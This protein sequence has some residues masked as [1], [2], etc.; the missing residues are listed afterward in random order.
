MFLRPLR[1]ESAVYVFFCCCPCTYLLNEKWNWDPERS[2][3][4]ETLELIGTG[5]NQLVKAYFPVPKQLLVLLLLLL[6]TT[7]VAAVGSEQRGMI[8]INTHHQGPSV[9]KHPFTKNM[10]VGDMERGQVICLN[11]QGGF[12]AETEMES[13]S[14]VRISTLTLSLAFIHVCWKM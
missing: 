6:L 8:C 12:V 11:S 13:I 9:I 2:V 4:V 3:V 1:P 10:W 7:M 14:E 5:W